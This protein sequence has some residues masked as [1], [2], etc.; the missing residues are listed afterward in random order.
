MCTQ[1]MF[2]THYMRKLQRHQINMSDTQKLASD[3][4]SMHGFN[5]QRG[6]LGDRTIHLDGWTVEHLQQQMSADIEVPALAEHTII[7]VMNSAR[8]QFSRFAGQTYEGVGRKDHFI[9]L[10]AEVPASFAWEGGDEAVTFDIKP[11]ALRQTALQTGCINP[12]HVELKPLVF[13]QD[14]QITAFAYSL[15]REI[16][17]VGVGSRLYSESLLTAFNIHL[18]RHYCSLEANLKEYSKG[19]GP[20]RLKKVL[21]YINNNLADSNIKLNTMARLAGLSKYHFARQFKQSTGLPPHQYVTYKRVEEAKQLLKERQLSLPRIA[22]ECGFSNQS[23]FGKAFRSVTG[24][25]PKRYRDN[26]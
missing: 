25:T 4:Y 7:L 26:V 21:D 2:A 8:R 18:L 14:E 15:L 23:Q 1:R 22:V 17:T 12:D 20:R 3:V 16:H 6:W 24:T 10:P 9:L 11:Q 13:S 19:L 5:K